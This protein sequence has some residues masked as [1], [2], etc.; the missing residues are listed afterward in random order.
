MKA[1]N[2]TERLYLIPVMS[3][4]IDVLELFQSGNPPLSLEAI[5]KLTRIPK[6]TLYRILR[7]WVHRGYLSQSED[8]LYRLV[9][10]PKKMRFGY[11]AQSSEMP[12][13]EEVT[14]SLREAAEAVGI[15]LIVLDNRYDASTA[16]KNADEFVRSKVDLV[17]E[18]QVEQE[19]AAKIGHRITSAGIP[20]I[21]VDIPHPHGTFFGVNNYRVGHDAGRALADHATKHWDGKVNWIVG[22]D[23]AEA[24]ILVQSRITA[25]FEGISQRI[26]ELPFECFV[27]IDCRGMRDRSRKMVL[28]F[29]RRHPQDRH[30]LI[31]AVNDWSALGALDAVQELKRERHV[32]IFGQNGISEALEVIKRGDSSFIGTISHAVNS[33]GPDLVNLGLSLLRAQPVPPHN[34]VVHQT[35]TANTLKGLD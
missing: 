5:Y 35:I 8:G 28:E 32:A 13:S 10:R 29:L 11:A 27:R 30:I 31:A 15:D 18:F 33:Y 26:P 22:L 3:K 12:F 21:A 23:L 25:A 24:G 9:L 4:A 1:R 19:V 14:A 20:L 16:L 2:P 6:T 7:T 17:I 34:Y